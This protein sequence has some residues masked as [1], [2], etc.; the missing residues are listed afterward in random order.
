M[1]H[2]VMTLVFMLILGG[3]GGLNFGIG[4]FVFGAMLGLL[5]GNQM[6]ISDRLLRLEAAA[7]AAQRARPATVETAAPA[8]D[9]EASALQRVS[10]EAAEPGAILVE[11]AA[12]PPAPAD[13]APVQPET[14]ARPASPDSAFAHA[15]SAIR[16]YATTGNVVA[17]AGV[18]LLFFGVAF[19][20]KYA[21]DRN[22]LPVEVRLAGTAAAAI[23]LL[24]TGFRMRGAR[25]SFGLLLQGA[26][27]GLLYLTAFAAT[28]LYQVL[29]AAACFVL[30][31]AVVL[32]SGVL[33]VRQDARALATLGAAGGFLAPVLASTGEGSHVMLFSYYALLNLGIV[34]VAWFKAWR[35]LNLTGFLFTFVIG[36]QWGYSYYRPE[37]FASVE[38]F[39]VFFF[40]LYLAVSVLFALRQPPDLRG[41]VD[42]TLV[43]GLPAIVFALQSRLVSGMPFAEAWSAVGMGAAY[44]GAAAWLQRQHRSELRTFTEALLALGVLALSLAIP[45]AFD[46]HLTAAAW[47][48]EGTGL[49]WI[50]LRQ[51]R[52]LARMAGAVLQVAAGVA[53]ALH[54]SVTQESTTAFLNTRFLGGAMIGAG[55]LASSCLLARG[56]ARL[57]PGERYNAT[58]LLLWGLCWW[59]VSGD[60]EIA[61]H[62]GDYAGATTLLFQAGSSVL[63]ARLARPWRWTGGHAAAAGLL[64]LLALGAIGE[65]ADGAG[66]VAELRWLG[67]C[68]ALAACWHALKL[69]EE[70]L[71]PAW[72]ARSH[73]LALWLLVYVTGWGFA[74]SAR[75]TWQLSRGWEL[76]LWLLP[77]AAALV[78]LPA[79]GHKLRWPVQP[80]AAVYLGRALLPLAV[81]GL[82]LVLLFAGDSGSAEPLAFLPLL[83]PLDLA[84]AGTLLAVAL[85]W[86]GV[87]G[88]A[89][90]PG[91]AWQRWLPRA[92]GATGFAAL[93]IAT[94]RA[95]HHL[96]AVPYTLTDLHRSP[97]FQGSTSVLWG[98]C[99]LALMVFAT[100]RGRR[101]LWIGGAVL[102]GALVAKLFFV[103]LGDRGTV[104]R[105]V[106][107]IAAGALMLLIGYLS[108][109]PP[110]RAEEHT[111]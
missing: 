1:L 89:H 50:G 96:A 106:S 95:V 40:A 33:A 109:A 46:G 39:L 60:S 45:L 99:A 55:A 76:A 41:R 110:R 83:N 19:L 111:P 28:R 75:W 2:A 86:H 47:A 18:L 36:S 103:D 61:R 91:A 80:F 100:R 105:I 6:R 84:S 69:G 12:P 26:G 88:S 108:P 90:E 22:A 13:L 44:L 87:A 27:V 30:M 107:F 65:T 101:S 104:A 3:M 85:W 9:T 54:G 52:P 43:F 62:A 77:V 14:I 67:W 70:R 58:A 51:Q 72:L 37:F 49:V 15:L 24:L 97:T 81:A 29:P 17:K 56:A 16:H 31:V 92:L 71:S 48:L 5:A 34:G 63:L 10:A 102:L 20:L 79:Q 73:A 35:A 66:P 11:D 93:N 53:F 32:L 57:R 82:T 21:I 94:A 25:A 78:L 38:P 74:W 68:A 7:E 59:L 64:V 4:G 8:Q 23:A 42:G 98:V